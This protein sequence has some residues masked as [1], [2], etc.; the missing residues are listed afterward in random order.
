MCKNTDVSYDNNNNSICQWQNIVNF[1]GQVSEAASVFACAIFF[2]TCEFLRMQKKN[3]YLYA[4][5]R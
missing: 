5:I 4:Q 3:M 1:R 2:F